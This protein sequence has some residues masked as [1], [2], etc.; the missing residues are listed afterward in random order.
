MLSKFLRGLYFGGG[1]AAA[2]AVFLIAACVIVGVVARLFHT[3]LP[4]GIEIATFCLVAASFLAL[5]HTFRHNVH[6]RI[7][8]ITQ[9]LP[10]RLIRP[11]EMFALFVAGI[12][13]FWLTYQT[14]NMTWEAFLFNDRSDGM[15]SIPLWIPEFCMTLG[16]FLLGV[17]ITEEFVRMCRGQ[18]PIYEQSRLAEG[19]DDFGADR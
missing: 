19:E 15:L 9:C 17:S 6:I 18:Q 14:G 7:T 3:T 13:S 5:A 11:F 2:V 10:S 12:A 4:G 8:V 16:I 1:I